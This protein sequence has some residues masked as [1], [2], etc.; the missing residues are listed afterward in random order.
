MNIYR[1]MEALYGVP[2]QASGFGFS[3]C[4]LHPLTVSHSDS[5]VPP[6]LFRLSAVLL[7][8]HT[9]LFLEKRKLMWM[10]NLFLW[11]KMKQYFVSWHRHICLNKN[12]NVFYKVI[13]FL[14]SILCWKRIKNYDKFSFILMTKESTLVNSG[15]HT[16]IIFLQSY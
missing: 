9:I 4:L 6:C 13:E 10:F 14:E 2:W 1:P 5:Q 8:P 15:I 12:D 16:W 3:V 7:H 11:I